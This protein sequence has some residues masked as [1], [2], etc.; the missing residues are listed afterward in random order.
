MP[1]T[2]ISITHPSISDEWHPTRNGDFRPEHVSQGSSKKVW[3]L[4]PKT[5]PEGCPHEWETMVSNRCRLNYGCPYCSRLTKKV[6]I[7]TSIVGTHPDIAAQWHPTKN[8]DRRPDQY[9]FG[10]EKKAWWLCH[11]TCPHGCPHEWEAEISKRILRGVDAGCPFCSS[12]HKK[13][14]IHDSI[15]TTHPHLLAEWHPTKNG[16]IKPEE[17]APG[18]CKQIWWSC[19]NTCSHGCVHEWQTRISD[20]AIRG[21][22]CPYCCKFRQKFCVHSTIQYTHPAIAVEWHP[23]KNGTVKPSDIVSGCDKPYWWV[24]PVN[25]AHEWC[26]ST[27]NRCTNGTGCP[28]CTNKTENKLYDY[29]KPLY[30]ELKR[31]FVLDDCKKVKKL[32]FDF[33]IESRKCIIEMDGGQH[34][35]QVSNWLPHTET[36]QRDVYKMRK[37][38]EAGYRVIRI[39]QTD[40]WGASEEKLHSTLVS[41]IESD[42]REHKYLS[43]I[44]GI[45]DR[46]NEMYETDEDFQSL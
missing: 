17:C 31:Q 20:R 22:G 13:V 34:F 7:H 15:V 24:C 1:P 43:S 19:P 9:S 10:S 21:S 16:E 42:T 26:T 32:R 6:C 29:L 38:A 37:A 33:C 4:C 44:P 35:R 18:S 25:A 2:P 36:Q 3:W 8:G 5:C 30:P 46:H 45:Y 41:E 23:T 28:L 40:V 11:V 27:S 39:L 14:C 12:N